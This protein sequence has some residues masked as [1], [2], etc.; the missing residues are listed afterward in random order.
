MPLAPHHPFRSPEARARYLA[1]YDEIAR[2]WPVPS[3]P[4]LVDTSFGPTFV[5]VS[6]PAG[7]PAMVLLSAL[8]S[9]C[10]SWIENVAGLSEHFTTYAVDNIHDH[11]RSVETRHVT[12]AE[13]LV[14]WL[15]DLLT[16][17]GLERPT[18]LV[19]LSYGGWIACRYAL[20]HPARVD[21]LVLLAPAATIAPIPWSFAWR[22]LLSLVPLRVTMRNFLGWIAPTLVHGDGAQRRMFDAMVEDACLAR[23][24]FVARRPVLPT[25]LRD[26]ELRRLPRNTLFLVGEHEVL[27]D[28]RR[29]VARLAQAAPHVR[30]EIVPG[31]GHDLFIAQTAEV[32]RRI[33][34][35]LAAT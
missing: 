26:E 23:R 15:D 29:A 16:G 6:G 12:T 34:G 22:G 2:L 24:S 27:Y 30:A 10:H 35:F 7:A 1:R 21:R 17:L 32:N 14:A 25:S 5:R 33:V 28:A 13:Q 20:A 19:G 4:R 9:P 18:G 31:C 11:G 8:G 3:E